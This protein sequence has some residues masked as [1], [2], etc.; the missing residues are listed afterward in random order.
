MSETIFRIQK[1][2]ENPFVMIDK[3]ITKDKRLSYK[4]KGI[5]VYLLGCPNDWIVNLVDVENQSTDGRD[6]VASGIKELINHGYVER[7]EHRDKGRFSHYEYLVFEVPKL[8][9]A[10]DDTANG[11]SDNGKTVS[12]KTA[13]GKPATTNKDIT[14]KDLTNKDLTDTGE[15]Q[16]QQKKP[17]KVK[18]KL[19]KPSELNQQLWDD[20]IS[21]RKQKKQPLTYSAWHDAKYNLAQLQLGV[22]QGHT[23]DDMVGVWLL[24]GWQGFK[25]EWYLNH[26]AKENQSQ[27]TQGNHSAINQPTYSP[28]YQQPV[29]S[30]AEIYRDKLMAEYDAFYGTAS[31]SAGSQGFS[32]NVYDLEKPV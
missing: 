5:L 14:K 26:V 11:K 17:K 31:E 10:S 18:P 27:N 8:V 29:K 25:F 2:A 12:G 20:L 23:M 30:D 4:A 32:G 1:N 21:L 6:S 24:R 13:N 9:A 3:R 7:I 22:S 15:K 28:N 16:Q 19:E